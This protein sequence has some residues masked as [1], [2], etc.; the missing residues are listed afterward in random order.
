MHIWTH[1]NTIVNNTIMTIG[2]LSVNIVAN[3]GIAETAIR[4]NFTA[5]THYS[6]SL[7]PG[8]WID[9]GIRTNLYICIHKGTV[10]VH[11][12]NAIVHQLNI[13]ATTENL[14]CSR[15]LQAGIDTQSGL[16]IISSY[17]PDFFS[18]VPENPQNIWQII[19][20][21]SIITAN[22]CQSSKQILTLKAINTGIYF[23]DFALFLSSILLLHNASHIT[24][25]ST[26][27]TAI[28]GSIW[29][30]SSQHGCLG[31][32]CLV[33]LIQ[34]GNKVCCYQRSITA[35]HHYSTLLIL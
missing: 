26:N 28:A 2:K 18:L 23:I 19:F 9:Y 35:Q 12:G 30:N 10:W 7:Q 20:T 13:L 8:K 32:C 3:L 25:S 27:N 5:C 16:I 14:L 6:A 11:Q 17:C 15:Q 33:S 22:L 1:S 4:A 21:L 34:L 29:H 24:V 31:S